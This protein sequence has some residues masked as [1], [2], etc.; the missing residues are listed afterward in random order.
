[1]PIVSTAEFEKTS[2]LS[3]FPLG[4]KS[5]LSE[6]TVGEF[7]HELSR[8]ILS[9]PRAK[10]FPDLITVGFFCRKSSLKVWKLKIPEIKYRRGIGTVT[11]IAPGNIPVNFAF[12]LLMG[13]ISGNSKLV[14]LHTR[15]F[16]QVSLFVEQLLDPNRLLARLILVPLVF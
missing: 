6:N 2:L 16:P 3:K 1:M 13:M 14:R 4:T 15:H 9:E 5:N 10:E 12:S 8:E 11:H 7:L